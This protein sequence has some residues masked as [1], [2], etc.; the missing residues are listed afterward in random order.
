[1]SLSKIKGV[2]GQKVD[3]ETKLENSRPVVARVNRV[4]RLISFCPKLASII[5]FSKSGCINNRYQLNKFK[6]KPFRH[7]GKFSIRDEIG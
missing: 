7:M 6:I 4:T 3:L 5:S 1:M 2:S